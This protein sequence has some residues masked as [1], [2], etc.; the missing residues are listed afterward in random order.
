MSFQDTQNKRLIREQLDLPLVQRFASEFGHPLHYFGLPGPQILDLVAWNSHVDHRT[1]VESVGRNQAEREEADN[2][3]SMML[4]NAQLMGRESGFEILRGDVEDVITDGMDS[5][6]YAVPL[7]D[8]PAQSARFGYHL[9]NLDFDGGLY[10]SSKERR[11]DRIASIRRLIE[12]QAETPFLLFLT[13]NVRD[14]L[15]TD[16]NRFLESLK[17]SCHSSTSKG[18]LDWAIGQR[19]GGRHHKLKIAVPAMVSRFATAMRVEA[20]CHPP[21]FYIGHE[22]ARMVHFPIEI[23]PTAH[24]LPSAA[25]QTDDDLVGLPLL[26]SSKGKFHLCKDC[27]LYT[28]GDAATPIISFID[29]KC[30]ET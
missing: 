27:N 9:A 26:I 4:L 5:G 8:G 6:G 7:S 25:L 19:R 23:R 2:V 30:V 10:F 13:I 11:L 12:R 14:A 20:L 15:G 16:L 18:I 3:A 22:K 24:K 1:A 21:V 17:A 29:A 28:V